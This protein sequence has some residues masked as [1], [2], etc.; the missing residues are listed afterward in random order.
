MR[1]TTTLVTVTELLFLV[2]DTLRTSTTMTVSIPHIAQSIM[3][4][5]AF[6]NHILTFFHQFSS[7]MD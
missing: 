3:Q 7:L 4:Y 2:P 6:S 1:D 5:K